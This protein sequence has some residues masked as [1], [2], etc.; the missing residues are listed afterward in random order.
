[1]NASKE[2][3]TRGV[4]AGAG[5]GAIRIGVASIEGSLASVFC[6]LCFLAT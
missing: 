1:M 2:R 4:G 6:F 3:E 5:A